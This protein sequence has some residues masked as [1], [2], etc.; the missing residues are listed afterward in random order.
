MTVSKVKQLHSRDQVTWNDPDQGLCSR[1]DYILDIEV[2]PGFR[3]ARQCPVFIR[4]I[5][6]GELEC[7][8]SELS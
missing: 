3:N 2:T 8:A 7:F 1:T 6:G 4:W 5:D